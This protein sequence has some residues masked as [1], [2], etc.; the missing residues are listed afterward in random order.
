MFVG[1]QYLIGKKWQKIFC[2]R[3][4]RNVYR[5]LM[6][7]KKIK[8]HFLS[9]SMEYERGDSFLFD[10]EPD[11]IYFGSISKEKLS[12][13]SYSIEFERKWIIFFWFA[14]VTVYIYMYIHIPCSHIPKIF[15]YFFYI[16]SWEAALKMI[17]YSW[18]C[19]YIDITHQKLYP[20]SYF[21]LENRPILCL[22][23]IYNFK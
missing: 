20:I 9:N 23:C 10:F 12:S 18:S 22:F 3:G 13:R 7:V 17:S 11:G 4:T 8:F 5:C 6:L 1:M 19:Y 21:R 14:Y 16:M 2:I 15:Y